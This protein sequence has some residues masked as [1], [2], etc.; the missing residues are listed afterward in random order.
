MLSDASALSLSLSISLPARNG[1]ARRLAA[2]VCNCKEREKI[3][4]GPSIRGMQSSQFSLHACRLCNTRPE[5]R[6]NSHSV[7]W[8]WRVHKS[9]F[10]HA[11]R[12][13]FS[14]C[15][16]HLLSL[17]PFLC[18][19]AR[20]P[21][22][23]FYSLLI[24]SEG[25]GERCCWLLLYCGLLLCARTTHFVAHHHHCYRPLHSTAHTKEKDHSH[26]HSTHS[27]RVYGSL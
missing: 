4:G 27:S 13:T 7:T 25:G 10:C 2:T 20:G 3:A 1:F 15:F 16:L 26:V 23:R 6:R 18:L 14:L 11:S 17:S 19:S 22:R 5:R 21:L 24:H 9:K 8:P 12:S